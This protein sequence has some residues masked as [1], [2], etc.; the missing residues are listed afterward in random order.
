[1]SPKSTSMV[2]PIEIKYEKPIFSS[3]AQS[4]TAVQSAPD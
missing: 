3:I 2:L 1:M 4:N